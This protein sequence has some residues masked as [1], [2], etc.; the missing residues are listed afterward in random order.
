MVEQKLNDGHMIKNGWTKLN[1][2]HKKF[3]KQ[4]S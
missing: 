2:W 4:R 1:D 3:T